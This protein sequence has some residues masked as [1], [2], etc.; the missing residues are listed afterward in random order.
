MRIPV[1]G[2]HMNTAGFVFAAILSAVIMFGTVV[3]AAN[4]G[5]SHV[6]VASHVTTL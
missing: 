6:Q 3:A 4:A 1:R 2:M 5:M